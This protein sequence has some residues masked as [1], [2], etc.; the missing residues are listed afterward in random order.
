MESQRRLT[1]LGAGLFFTSAAI[2]MLEIC[3][4]RVFS[5]MMWYH[6]A[7]FT[8]SVALFGFAAS[9]LVVHLK[10]KTFTAERAPRQAALFA[11][12]LAIAAPVCFALLA[13]NPKQGAL[14]GA[15]T[16]MSDVNAGYTT[17][18]FVGVIV[19]FVTAVAPF[20]C[21]GM[22]ISILFRHFGDKAS[23]LYFFDLL[24]GGLGCL[25][26][27]LVLD[28]FG[29][30]GSMAFVSILAAI[31]GFLFLTVDVAAGRGRAKPLMGALIVVAA[32]LALTNNQ[33]RL[34][35]LKYY[36]GEVQD[37]VIFEDWN[38]FSRVA[39]RD[40]FAADSLLIEIDAASNTFA[41]RWDGDRAHIRDVAE[42]LISLQYTFLEQ[43][44]VLAI[45]SGG[46]T[47]I[48]AALAAGSPDITGVEVNPIIVDIM[49][50]RFTDYTG[51]VYN[52]PE[53]RIVN[54]EA[55]SY[56]RRSEEKYDCIQAG[57]VD[58][59]AATAAGAF[60]L[61]E[62]TLYT[63]E[64]Y[65]DYLDHLTPDG[66]IS[67]QRYYE[68]NPQQGVRLVSVAMQA[69]IERGT[70]NPGRHIVVARKYDRATVLVKNSP[71]SDA[72]VEALIARCT[73]YDLDLVAA[74]GHLPDDIY[75]HLL[76][77]DDLGPVLDGYELDISPVY[78]DRPF[79]FY[80]IRPAQ[81]WKGLL[82]RSGEF[83]HARAVFLLVALLILVTVVSVLVFV[84]PAIFHRRV[85]TKQSLPALAYFGAL[86][87][88]FMLVEIGMLQRMMLFLGHPTLALSVVLSSVL[89][90]AGLGSA[91]TGR[92]GADVLK[93][94]LLAL[95]GVVVALVI[96]A[97]FVW[98]PLLTAL[99][100]LSRAGRVLVAIAFLFP[101]G[102]FLGTAFPLG[103]RRLA[104]WNPE[105]IPWAWAING[106][107]SVLGSVLAM[108]LAINT[109]FTAVLLVGGA[110][111]VVALLMARGET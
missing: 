67:F 14:T 89:I 32:L 53:V 11:A 62:N 51:N 5:V 96:V 91:W 39:V 88:G 69:L 81:F 20:F 74:P 26:S 55:R 33:T 61:T 98:G 73:Q 7:F 44:K 68:E 63:V 37:D 86:G 9:G 27:I 85:F 58:T 21:G 10:P 93:N 50:N 110:V 2:L 102:F 71:F 84:L 49:K 34:L 1:S 4:T 105:L 64:A 13:L 16:N 80:V 77:A 15:L 19:L 38:S 104:G 6:F 42:D 36:R 31:A 107:T 35:D 78:D 3:L 46:G 25:A 65:R 111:Y 108:A 72:E 79:F 75:G 41:A 60:A 94:R 8:I 12:G 29:G 59:Y 40:G 106:A 45:G 87:L 97:A 66:I 101:L 17:L 103:L 48:L 90:S 43:P 76:A 83:Q 22:V 23:K 57:Y 28:Y 92:I 70:P 52:Q 30:P 100:H 109:G 54:D 99:I 24:G 18:A 95:L 82:L 56:I 47:D